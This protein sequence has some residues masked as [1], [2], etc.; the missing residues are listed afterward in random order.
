MDAAHDVLG[1]SVGRMGRAPVAANHAPFVN[2][3]GP[4]SDITRVFAFKMR[5]VPVRLRML[6][7]GDAPHMYLLVQ[8]RA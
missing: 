8:P 3:T 7:Q 4:Q 5:P 1:P 2:C 6:R